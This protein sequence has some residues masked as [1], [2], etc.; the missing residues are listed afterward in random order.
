MSASLLD[1]LTGLITPDVV[2]NAA[3]M[4]GESEAAIR[5]GVSGMFPAVLSNLASRSENP[6]FAALLFELMRSPAN[7]GGVLVDISS[8]FSANGSLPMMNLGRTLLGS[9]FGDGTAN[10]ANQL[11]GYAGIKNSTA[12]TLLNVAAPLVLAFLGKRARHDGLNACSL[13]TLLHGEKHFFSAAVP[14]QLSNLGRYRGTSD[15]ERATYT[16]P[17]PKRRV[18][19][20]RWLLPALAAIVGFALFDRKDPQV[21]RTVAPTGTVYLDIDR[22]E[23]P[24]DAI[25]LLMQKPILTEGGAPPEQIRR[26]EVNAS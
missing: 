26:V 12:K 13:V 11:A 8:L 6:G 7:D 16:P 5:K 20:L 9:L 15:T 14:S 18:S 25:P 24:A 22:S 10:F 23:P 2:G 1:G 21:P 4:L 3:S 19:V 17:P